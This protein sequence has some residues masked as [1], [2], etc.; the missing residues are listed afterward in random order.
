M[1][2]T[3]HTTERDEEITVSFAG[4]A[5]VPATLAGRDP[6]TDLAVLRIENGQGQPAALGDAE[7]LR[8]GHVV[9][10]VGRGP[11]VSLGAVS[12]TGGAWRTW[13]G[14]Q[15]DQM[16]QLDVSIYYGFSGGALV[17]AE[18]KIAGLNTSA[19]SRGAAIAIPAATVSRVVEEIL[20]RGHIARGYLGVGMQPVRLPSVGQRLNLDPAA[21][22]IILSVEPDSPAEK[23]GLL[24]GDVIVALNGK[25]VGD[26]EDVQA[27][28]DP[29]S[30][31]KALQAKLVRGGQLIE[32]PVVVGERPRG[33]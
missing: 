21:G 26:T 32:I 4:G 17:N 19:L 20:K 23:A 12:S 28:L 29:S 13:R 9:L 30:V 18:G 3:H 31:G 25:T 2:T 7:Q 15:V 1:V 16:I 27:V 6:Q 11:S 22:V 5:T 24:V 10:T 8:P 14:G 33:Y